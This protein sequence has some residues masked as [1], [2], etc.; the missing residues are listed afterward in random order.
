MPTVGVSKSLTRSAAVYQELVD[1]KDRHDLGEYYTPDWLCERIVTDL[2][3]GPDLPRTLDPTCGSGSFLRAAITRLKAI[4]QQGTSAKLLGTILDH[5]FGIDIHP[6]AVTIAKATYLLALGDLVREAK[7]PIQIPVYLA[8][9]LFLPSEVQQLRF[10]EVPGYEIRFGGDR[11]V[12]VPETLVRMPELFDPA[13]AACTRIAVDHAS[14]RK[15]SERSLR[16]YVKQSV[17][18]LASQPDFD[19]ISRALWSFTEEL[20]DLI[21]QKKDSIWAFIVRNAYR[22]AMFR[23]RFDVIVGNPPWLSYRYI[24]DP[25]YQKEVKKRALDDYA[26]APASQ[27]L[28]TQMELATVFLVHTL[29][30]FGRDRARLGFVMPRSV[31]SADQHAP[32]RERTYRAPVVIEGYW[33]LVEVAPVF[34]VPSCVLF[35]TKS[36]VSPGTSYVLPA[37]EW[38]GRLSERDAP[39]PEAEPHLRTTKASARVTYLGSRSALTTG[40]GKAGVSAPSSYEGRFRQG[41]T[42]VPRSLYFVKLRESNGTVKPDKVY[43][44]ETDPEQALQ[45]KPPY[46]DVRMKG[47]VEGCFLF[48][49]ALSRHVL[50]FALLEPAI[51]VLPLVEVDGRLEMRTADRLRKDG[52]REFAGWMSRAERIW[53]EK[54]KGKAEKQ[55]VY[56]RLDYNAELTEQSLRER[57]LVLYNAAGTN[58]A[59]TRVDRHVL[60]LPFV[61]EHKLYWAA[62]D[63]DREANYLV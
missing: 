41:A 5:V 43:S 56:E 26:I 11:R 16:T 44:A 28:M 27:K 42:L 33:D 30:T 60:P 31:L 4:S 36:P 59:A 3:P 47:E 29:S 48:S 15:E 12:S 7:R 22:P 40:K 17:P 24:A 49:T 19:A 20:A 61:V 46:G 53:A 14:S 13:I 23:E 10:G 18:G 55:S 51:V 58:L 6:V 57:H 21:R 62:I 52:Y 39:W 25:E 38:A 35:A 9:S 2:F 63:D 54:R 34:K 1:P 37:L 50:P 32:L 8:D 45:A